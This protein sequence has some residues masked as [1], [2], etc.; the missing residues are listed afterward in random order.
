MPDPALESFLEEKAFGKDL[1]QG[2]GSSGL[3]GTG[4]N[5]DIKIQGNSMKQ[6]Y[7]LIYKI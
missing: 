6:R 4:I 1:K 5:Q 3:S 7:Y 2:R